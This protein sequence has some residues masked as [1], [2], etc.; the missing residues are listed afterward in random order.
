MKIKKNPTIRALR[1]NLMIPSSM[2]EASIETPWK[3]DYFSSTNGSPRGLAFQ[4]TGGV[5]RSLT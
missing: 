4:I 5:A 1:T 3:L 2:L